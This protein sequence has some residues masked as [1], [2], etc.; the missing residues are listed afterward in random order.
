M[1]KETPQP[2]SDETEVIRMRQTVR[3]AAVIFLCLILFPVSVAGAEQ[4]LTAIPLLSHAFTLLEEGNPFIARYN[5][6]TGADIRARMPL[7]VPYL[8]GG[9]TTSHVFAKEP[10]YVVLPAWSSSPAYYRKGLNYLYGYDCYGYVAWAWQ[11]TFGYQMDTMDMMFEDRDMH[12]MDSARTPEADFAVL[13][14]QLRPG[15]LLLVEHPGRHIGIYIGTLRM[16]GYTEE[17][18]PELSGF[19]DEPLI[20]N[21]TVNAQ[22]SDRF[23]DLI[24]NGLPKYRGTTVTDGGVCVSL[25]CRDSS[26]VPHTVHQQNQDT[27]YFLLPDGTWLPVFLWET[28]LRY[29]WYRTPD[30]SSAP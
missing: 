14:E 8:W 28:V 21:S 7:G 26:A 25:V 11:E 27:R 3:R 10:D 24:A 19:L 9:R 16:Y 4:K 22:I 5:S 6:V 2:V 13:A 18:A 29:C 30:A 1:K 17:E 23:A 20:I 12:V 15:D